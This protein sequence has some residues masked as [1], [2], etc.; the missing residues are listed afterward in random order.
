MKGK[1]E[2]V[3]CVGPS[4]LPFV[5]AVSGPLADKNFLTIRRVDSSCGMGEGDI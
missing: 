5:C 1:G 3:L 4:S 2:E